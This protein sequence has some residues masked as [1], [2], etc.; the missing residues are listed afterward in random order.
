MSIVSA[1]SSAVWPVSAPGGSAAK[2]ASPGAGLEVRPVGDL[3]RDEPEVD[4][5]AAASDAAASASA[6]DDGPQAVVDVDRR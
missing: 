1:R 6:A 4:A 3:D 2:R 5:D